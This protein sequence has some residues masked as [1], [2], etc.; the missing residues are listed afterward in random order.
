MV[1]IASKDRH[2][3]LNSDPSNNKKRSSIIQL[4]V[5]QG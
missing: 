2:N 3:H 1:I 4:V 5:D